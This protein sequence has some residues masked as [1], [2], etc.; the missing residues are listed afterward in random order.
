MPNDF[1]T[2]LGAYVILIVGIFCQNVIRLYKG[3]LFMKYLFSYTLFAFG[4][5][6]LRLFSKYFF[7][8]EKR[9]FAHNTLSLLCLGS[10]IW[11]FGFSA[12]FMQ[13][14]PEIAYLCRAIGMVG[15][16]IYLITG[17]MMVCY[18]SPLSK[19]IRYSLNGIALTGILVWL[20]T[21]QRDQVIFFMEND[22][23]SYSFVPGIVSNVYTA[24]ST[25]VALNT[26]FVA[27]HMIAR[28]DHKR[29]QAFGRH[30]VVAIVC[31]GIGMVF[32]TVFPLLGKSAFPGST[33]TQF[34]GMLVICNAIRVL[35]H[36][37]LNIHNMSMFI[38]DSL[39]MPI[40]VYDADYQI[41][42]MND[43]ASIFFGE[44][45]ELSNINEL[46]IDR[47]FEL[48][49]DEVFSFEG[50][51][52][53]VS[54]IC[55]NNQIFCELSISKIH[56]NYGD[57]IGYIIIVAD[58]SDQIKAMHR[59]EEAK[60]EAETANKTKSTF[61]ANM[62]HEIRTPMNAI[63]GLSELVLNMDLQNEVRECVTD[64]KTSSK[65]LLAIIN[66]ILD[67][68]RL[69]S[70]KAEVICEP[71]YT[72][73]ILRDIRTII[74]S[75]A[76]QKGLKFIMNLD[77]NIPDKLYGDKVRIRGI[78]INLLNNAVKYTNTGSITFSMKVMSTNNDTVRLEYKIIDTGIGIKDDEIETI[79]D[80][81]SQVNR[82]IN[83]SVEGTGLGLSIVKGYV[84]LMGGHISVASTYGKGSM[85]SVI[86]EQKIL[87]NQSIHN[88]ES[89]SNTSVDE[90]SLG[91]MKIRNITA[92]VVD[93]N[94]MNLKVSGRSI[95]H[96]GLEV[97]TASSG[98]DAIKLCQEKSYDLI[99]MDQ[100]MPGMDGVEAMQR[101]RRLSPFYDHGGPC[102]IVVLTANAINGMREQLTGNGF[103]DYLGK[104]INFSQ[105]E[106]IFKKYIPAEKISFEG[107]E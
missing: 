75:Q 46:P 98:A 84:K 31:I 106:T 30:L 67:I 58:M 32:D 50:G 72:A 4:I 8:K 55:R 28:S 73:S 10:A 12:L 66:D 90:F 74:N 107:E 64:I 81:F 34:V 89:L 95:S 105:L 44:Y 54:S 85:F 56:D 1:L 42:I 17:Q 27:I 88:I 21:C 79:F 39:S 57:L 91:S 19:K 83:R 102:K 86:L 97:D 103:D 38:Y 92:L 15:V 25:I 53:H 69:E 24:Y 104:P 70:G 62:S 78:L 22:M 26:L 101:I 71:Y 77:P 100:M 6:A 99:F 14:N 18:L 20:L 45:R 94:K 7:S 93:D 23:M 3:G 43:T 29:D 63:I 96:Y 59:L 40:L 48:D 11:S 80:S 9:G 2:T 51:I 52:Q 36:S 61:L 65:N 87:D 41:K 35:D 13:T 76:Q 5:L 47:L 16:F 37:D 33:M 60:E 82:K 68:S 49:Q